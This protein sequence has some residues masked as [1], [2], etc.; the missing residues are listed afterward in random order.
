MKKRS[1]MAIAAGLVAALL[2]GAVALSLG[3]SATDQ[4]DAASERV[5]PR[6]RTVHRTVTV[7]REA[8]AEEPETVTIVTAGSSS[9]ASG[10]DEAASDDR[11][12][13]VDDGVEDED[14]DDGTEHEDEA[15]GEEEHEDEADDD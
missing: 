15:E 10:D 6:V 5:E 12:E 1:A 13:G 2:T 7:H 11:S 14:R 9:P 3:L 4:A 8:K